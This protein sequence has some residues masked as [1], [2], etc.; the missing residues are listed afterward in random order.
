MTAK[1]KLNKEIKEKFYSNNGIPSPRDFYNFVIA[2]RKTVIA[3]L[4]EVIKMDENCEYVS[5]ERLWEAIDQSVNIAGIE[6]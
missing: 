6:D 5:D 1:E 3:P 4:N 2:D